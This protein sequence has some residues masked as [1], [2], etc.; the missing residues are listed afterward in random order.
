MRVH[1]GHTTGNQCQASTA[2]PLSLPPTFGGPPQYAQAGKCP[3]AL[4]DKPW[5][6]EGLQCMCPVPLTPFHSGTSSAHLFVQGNKGHR[7]EPGKEAARGLEGSWAVRKA[8]PH[9]LYHTG[10]PR[11]PNTHLG[12]C[13]W[14]RLP[15]FSSYPILFVPSYSSAPSSGRGPASSSLLPSRRAFLSLLHGCPHATGHPSGL[16]CGCPL[17]TPGQQSWAGIIRVSPAQDA[18]LLPSQRTPWPPGYN[19]QSPPESL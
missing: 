15:W 2:A 3:A 10:S 12:C 16:Q 9:W 5:P 7:H 11:S 1:L 14:L 19:S 13:W 4:G 6:R 8:V 17:A 18:S